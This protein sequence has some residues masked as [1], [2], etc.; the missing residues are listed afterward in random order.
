MTAIDLNSNLGESFGAW[1]M[2]DDD[3]SAMFDIVTSANVACGYAGL[4]ASISVHIDDIDLPFLA[5]LA[6]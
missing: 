4:H 5:Q 2:G 1:T 6:E 3:D